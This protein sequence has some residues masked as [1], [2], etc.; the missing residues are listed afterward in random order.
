MDESQQTS[1]PVTYQVDEDPGD[2][3]DNNGNNDNGSSRGDSQE[4]I[5]NQIM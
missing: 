2:N 5:D 1:Q 4:V 3:G